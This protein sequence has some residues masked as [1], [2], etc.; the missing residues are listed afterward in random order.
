MACATEA[1][2][3]GS[4]SAMGE[5]KR[6]TKH[7]HSPASRNVA[8]CM[9][10]SIESAFNISTFRSHQQCG[11]LRSTYSNHVNG[12][13]RAPPKSGRTGNIPFST[14]ARPE[15]TGSFRELE[16]AG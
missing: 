16:I 3:Q 2:I 13:F 14:L 12:R 4:L 15:R 9:R 7:G 8:T 1:E 6:A 11:A 10:V 5:W